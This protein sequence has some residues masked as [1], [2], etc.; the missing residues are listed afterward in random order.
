[1]RTRI[2]VGCIA[3]VAW[4]A[5]VCPAEAPTKAAPIDVVASAG[6]PR[7]LQ[8]TPLLDRVVTELRAGRVESANSA[9]K[10]YVSGAASGGAVDPN[11]LVQYVLRESY[12]QTAE[13]L[14]YL[15]EKVKYF[16]ESK[17]L[18]REYLQQLRDYSPQTK[19]FHCLNW[20]KLDSRPCA[21]TK[22]QV[23]KEIAA[24]EERL[25]SLGD[26]AQRSAL[27]LQAAMQKQQQLM[28]TLSNVSKTLHDTA[29]AII[30]NLRG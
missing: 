23:E 25:N 16:N 20:P 19:D 24:W 30:Q 28:Q 21:L 5:V 12:L 14:R 6:L 22:D 29:K 18:V 13:D 26:D 27:D 7:G 17:K 1:M 9:F 4:S 8:R 11:A 3:L 10:Q 2:H 15:A